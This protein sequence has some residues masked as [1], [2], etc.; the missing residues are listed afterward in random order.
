[1]VVLVMYFNLL[2]STAD[3]LT[4]ADRVFEP[5]D[6][7]KERES[8]PKGKAADPPSSTNE[9]ANSLWGNRTFTVGFDRCEEF[10][11]NIPEEKRFI[12]HAGLFNSGTSLFPNVMS[13]NCK[14]RHKGGGM[15]PMVPWGKHNPSYWRG[16]H[17]V[18]WVDESF[19]K[20]DPN[21]KEGVNQF[22]VVVIVK[23]PFFW[24]QSM[25]SHHWQMEVDTWGE[26]WVEGGVALAN[27]HPT[28]PHLVHRDEVDYSS[29]MPKLKRFDSIKEG[30][31]YG[32]LSS[33]NVVMHYQSLTYRDEDGIERPHFPPGQVRKRSGK[34]SS[35][36]TQKNLTPK[37]LTGDL[38]KHGGCLEHLARRLL[39][40]GL[41]PRFH[42]VRGFAFSARRDREE[43]LRVRR[44]RVDKRRRVQPL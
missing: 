30:I 24:M 42:Q 37:P 32:K 16:H 43:G 8:L 20:L 39:E 44:W 19:G 10:R 5:I 27:N 26:R 12:G 1:M 38:R 33:N 31:S 34:N 28:C 17:T 6:S 2:Y 36:P 3:R 35:I 22:M 41:S 40:G 7:K 21:G 18:Q 11:N 9:K 13:H 14:L 25:C 29:P 15:K 4:I 23:D